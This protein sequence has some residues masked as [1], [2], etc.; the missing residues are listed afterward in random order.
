MTDETN[1]SAEALE[2]I[3]EI[4]SAEEDH[5]TATVAGMEVKIVDAPEGVLEE[6]IEHHAERPDPMDCAACGHRHLGTYT[7]GGGRDMNRCNWVDGWDGGAPTE[8]CYCK[9]LVPEYEQEG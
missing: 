9:D 8:F 2:R 1:R 6:L 5:L 3:D 4:G 7:A